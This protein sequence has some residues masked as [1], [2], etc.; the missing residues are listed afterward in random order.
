VQ[1]FYLRGILE[2]SLAEVEA[3]VL[4]S[5][6]LVSVQRGRELLQRTYASRHKSQVDFG[7]RH[8]GGNGV[9][10]CQGLCMMQRNA[11]PTAKQ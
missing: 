6:R 10:L 1:A 5:Q 11:Q 4:R 3:L 7:R 8:S 2:S 9:W